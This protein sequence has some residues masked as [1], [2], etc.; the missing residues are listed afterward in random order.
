MRQSSGYISKGMGLD[1]ISLHQTMVVS[2]PTQLVRCTVD[3]GWICVEKIELFRF[4]QRVGLDKPETV[5]VKGRVTDYI[6]RI[7]CHNCHAFRE[8]P[9]YT[10][11]ALCTCAIRRM[12]G[13]ESRCDR[14]AF[15]I[16]RAA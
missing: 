2:I 11:F 12:D 10:P 14:I 16:H 3:L 8:L 1:P 13:S 9:K 4:H 7:V 15:S 6:E 5:N